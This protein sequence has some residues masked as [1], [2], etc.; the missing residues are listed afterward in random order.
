MPTY[1]FLNSSGKFRTLNG[2][3]GLP[4]HV[5]QGPGCQLRGQNCYVEITLGCPRSDSDKALQTN[6]QSTKNSSKNYIVESIAARRGDQKVLPDHLS[7][8]EKA[9]IYPAEAVVVPVIQKSFA[10]SSLKR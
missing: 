6:S 1:D 5:S 7:A 10:R 4:Y 8:H 2:Y 9:F 3:I